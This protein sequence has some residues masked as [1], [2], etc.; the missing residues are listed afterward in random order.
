MRIARLKRCVSPKASDEFRRRWGSRVRHRF[1]SGN[2]AKAILKSISDL[3]RAT[4]SFF[5]PDTMIWMI[6]GGRAKIEPEVRA[7]NFGA[8]RFLEADGKPVA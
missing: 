6:V 3:D 1:D 4:R 8:L 2:I 7:L 5:N